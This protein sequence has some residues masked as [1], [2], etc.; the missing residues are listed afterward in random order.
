MI[1][2]YIN[3]YIYTRKCSEQYIE[4][5]CLFLAI[6]SSPKLIYKLGS[7]S[8]PPSAFFQKHTVE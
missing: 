5:K 4:I 7:G 8:E 2:T 3:E 6:T 1:Y